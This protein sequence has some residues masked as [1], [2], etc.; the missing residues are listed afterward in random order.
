MNKYQKR[1]R[2][3]VWRVIESYGFSPYDYCKCRKIVRKIKKQYGIFIP[4]C[5]Q[6]EYINN[7]LG[8]KIW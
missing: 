2:K 8:V 3:L 6:R 1:E 5:F 4:Y 7:M